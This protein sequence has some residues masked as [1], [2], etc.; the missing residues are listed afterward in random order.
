LT[1]SHFSI[2]PSITHKMKHEVETRTC[3]KQCMLTA[4]C[5]V[6]HWCNRLSEVWPWPP[7]S[8]SFTEA[9]TTVTAKEISDTTLYTS[10][11]HEW[12]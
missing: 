3:V 2:L 4:R 10:I 7:L 9:V 8:S 11:V 1:Q 5:H 6:P 12:G